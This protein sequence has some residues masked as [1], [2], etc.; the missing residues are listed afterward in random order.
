MHIATYIQDKEYA[1]ERSFVVTW[2]S[3]VRK[4][5]TLYT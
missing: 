1:N 3:A 5:G 4:Q 2:M